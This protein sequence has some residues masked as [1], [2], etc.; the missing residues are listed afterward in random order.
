LFEDLG[1]LG[2][3]NGLG[4]EVEGGRDAA[5]ED[6]ELLAPPKRLIAFEFDWTPKL[7]RP[8]ELPAVGLSKGFVEGADGCDPAPVE[9]EPNAVGEIEGELALVFRPPNPFREVAPSEGLASA[10]ERLDPVDKACRLLEFPPPFQAGRL[11]GASVSFDELAADRAL[12]P[13]KLV[14]VAAVRPVVGCPNEVSAKFP[15]VPF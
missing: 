7:E 9:S 4:F 2:S 8:P 14:G 10:V 6:A 12:D 3:G 11:V 1:R 15:A 13:E 5:R